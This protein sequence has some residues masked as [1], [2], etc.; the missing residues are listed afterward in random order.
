VN[1]TAQ[2]VYEDGEPVAIASNMEC[3]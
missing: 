2:D 1:V 3:L